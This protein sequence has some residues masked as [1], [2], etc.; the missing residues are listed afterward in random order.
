MIC[1]A[2]SL[3]ACN[4]KRFP[5]YWEEH[6]EAQFSCLSSLTPISAILSGVRWPVKINSPTEAEILQEI[7]TL[8]CHKALRFDGLSKLYL[9]M[10]EWKWLENFKFCSEKSAL[11][12][13]PVVGSILKK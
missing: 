13:E 1:E 10:G 3:T 7:Q 9:I 4:Q 12:G 11:C 6:L 2:G 5:V 8:G